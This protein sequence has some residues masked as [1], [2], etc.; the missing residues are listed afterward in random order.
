MPRAVKCVLVEC[1]P[2]IKS[3]ILNIDSKAHNSIVIEDLDDDH[4]VISDNKVETVKQELEAQLSENTFNPIELE[5]NP[6]EK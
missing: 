1:D 3:L 6:P 4:L 5:N 2:S